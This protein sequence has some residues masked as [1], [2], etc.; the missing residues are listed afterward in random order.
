MRP[1]A[2]NDAAYFVA[3]GTEV[4]EGLNFPADHFKFLRAEGATVGIPLARE[5]NPQIRKLVP[6]PWQRAYD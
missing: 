6:D 3:D 2:S 1:V 4:I 5:P